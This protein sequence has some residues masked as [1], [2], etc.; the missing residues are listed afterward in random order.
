MSMAGSFCAG[1]SDSLPR[2]PTRRAVGVIGSHRRR[3]RPRQT[4]LPAAP[5]LGRPVR[6]AHLEARRRSSAAGSPCAA[7]SSTPRT[8]T[9]NDYTIGFKAMGKMSDFFNLGVEADLQRRS[10]A[11][12]VRCCRV[13]RPRRQHRPKRGDD[14]RGLLQSLPHLGGLRHRTPSPPWGPSICRTRRGLRDSGRGV[15]GTSRAGA[16]SGTPTGAGGGRPTVALP[17]PSAKWSR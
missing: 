7:A 17:S 6:P 1:N 15:G 5:K 8:I 9:S 16:F 11:D 13:H 2:L 12:F 4:A 3:R 14:V 10:S